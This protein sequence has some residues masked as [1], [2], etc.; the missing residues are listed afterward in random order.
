MS[1]LSGAEKLERRVDVSA[2]ISDYVYTYEQNYTKALKDNPKLNQDELNKKALKDFYVPN[3]T[4]ITDAMYD[5]ETG[6]AALAVEDSQ[7]GETYIAYAGT[8]MKADGMTD[9]TSD[10]AIGTNDALYLEELEKKAAA[11]YEKVERQGANITVSAGHSYGDFLSSRVA[12]LKQIPYKF[13]FQGAPQAVSLLTLQETALQQ[14]LT[15]NNGYAPPELF[16]AAEASRTAADRAKKLVA[17]YQGYA[18]TFSTTRDI[19]TNALWDQPKGEIS[20]DGHID[21]FNRNGDKAASGLMTALEIAMGT[22]SDPLYLGRVQAVDVPVFHS[23][24]DYRQSAE[25]M[26]YSRQIV[27]EEAYGVDF[28]R[29]GSLEFAVTPDYLTS[30]PLLPSFASSG[31]TIKLDTAALEGL[32]G[33]LGTVQSQLQDLIDLTAR[34]SAENLTVMENMSGRQQNLKTVIVEHLHNISLVKAIE[35]IDKACEDLEELFDELPTLSNYKSSA[36]SGQFDTWTKDWFKGEKGWNPKTTASELETMATAASSLKSMIDG[37]ILSQVSQITSSSLNDWLT[38]ALDGGLLENTSTSALA[39]KGENLVNQFEGAIEASL[40]G[41]GSRSQ[42]ADGLPQ[43]VH[44]LLGVI[45]QNLTSLLQAVAYTSSVA[46]TIKTTMETADIGLANAISTFDTSQIPDVAVSVSESYEGYL[47]SSGVFDDRA[48]LS[49]FDDQVDVRSSDLAEDMSG[50]FSTYLRG[51]ED[52]LTEVNVKMTGLSYSL[53]DLLKEAKKTVSYKDKLDLKPDGQTPPKKTFGP[54][55]KA[56]SVLETMKTVNTSLT[57][58]DSQMTTALTT[59][60]TVSGMLGGFTPV[61]RTGMED[62]FYG[63]AGLEA[64]V[65]SQKA[66]GQILAA[67]KARFEELGQELATINEGEAVRALGSKMQDSTQLMGHAATLI[68][69][70][71]GD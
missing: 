4:T 58:I 8:N 54:L 26:A 35:D 1:E 36:F 42:F 12:A 21:L 52:S 66:V 34:A 9:V 17:D 31:G 28:G 43:A 38:E 33:N 24:R 49:A 70:C 60:N 19:L 5:E 29:D 48:V 39:K 46:Q 15:T 41:L 69:D 47:E 16:T 27:L 59:I 56:I 67:V 20:F 25:A 13:G 11:F 7:T 3:N 61:F 14:A 44:E 63:A 2:E 30:Q 65:R 64:I 53:D 71:F 51:A 68:E 40:Q 22:Q 6:V 32:I 50:Q 23:M 62:A 10:M 45:A 57:A 37:E 18:I 55:G